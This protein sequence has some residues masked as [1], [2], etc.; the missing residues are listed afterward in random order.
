MSAGAGA[1][2]DATEAAESARVEALKEVDDNRRSRRN[3]V[4]LSEENPQR[5]HTQSAWSG[6]PSAAGSSPAASLSSPQNVGR[7]IGAGVTGRLGRSTADGKSVRMRLSRRSLRPVEGESIS[8]VPPS[9]WRTWG[10]VRRCCDSIIARTYCSIPGTASQAFV[11]CEKLCQFSSAVVGCADDGGVD[12]PSSALSPLLGAEI[13]AG[14][15]GSGGVGSGGKSSA[16]T[17]VGLGRSCSL[18]QG[19]IGLGFS[20]TAG[21]VLGTSYHMSLGGSGYDCGAWKSSRFSLKVYV[22]TGK[23][24]ASGFDSTGGA[25]LEYRLIRNVML[26][27]P[28]VNLTVLRPKTS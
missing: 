24:A 28:L 19:K 8:S 25:E 3:D 20:A 21:L 12:V 5:G 1:G 16:K 9:C 10:L 23:L 27:R 22:W 26:A 6:T 18:S 17:R 2:A 15:V 7:R 14:S 4:A 13:G 11:L